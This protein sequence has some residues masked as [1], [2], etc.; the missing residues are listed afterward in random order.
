MLK[1]GMGWLVVLNL[2]IRVGIIENME[3]EQTYS[4]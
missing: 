4:R 3:T 1:I 2:L